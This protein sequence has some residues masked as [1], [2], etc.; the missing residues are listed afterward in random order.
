[1]LVGL[2]CAG[3]AAP[4][5]LYDLQFFCDGAGCDWN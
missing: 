1:M 3:T 2:G 4:C 5:E